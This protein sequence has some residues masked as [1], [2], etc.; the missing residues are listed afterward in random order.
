MHPKNVSEAI[1]GQAVTQTGDQEI[2]GIKDFKDG[3]KIIGKEPVLTNSTVDYAMV[4]KDNNASVMSGGSLKL[5]RRGDLVYL[6]G[7]FQLSA[8]KDNQAVWFNIP[9]WAYP[10]EAVRMYGKTSDDKMCLLYM[11]TADNSNIVC[12]DSV[13]KGAWITISSCWMAKN[14]Y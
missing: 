14:P 3:I 12:K 6:T 5:Y 8:L 1:S 11:N 9:T 4:D 10:I 7:S 13:A 2:S